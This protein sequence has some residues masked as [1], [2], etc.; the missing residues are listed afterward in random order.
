M[1]FFIKVFPNFRV[2]AADLYDNF[3]DQVEIGFV[4][5]LVNDVLNE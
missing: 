4:M 3:H 1:S 5:A 2:F